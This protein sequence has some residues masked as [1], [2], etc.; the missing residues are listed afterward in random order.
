MT[1]TNP[2]TL[3]QTLPGLGAHAASYLDLQRPDGAI[4]RADWE[5]DDPGGIAEL[6]KACAW[7]CGRSAFGHGA[8]DAGAGL[9]PS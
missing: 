9:V 8:A 7:F 5:L 6:E 1:V 2:F 3:A 4:A